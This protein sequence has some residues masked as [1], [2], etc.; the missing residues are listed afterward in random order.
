ARAVDERAAIYRTL[1]TC[2]VGGESVPRRGF[3][4]L[5]EASDYP[6]GVV[7]PH[8]RTHAGPKKDRLDLLEATRADVG[9]LFMLV[10][11]PGGELLRAT[12]PSGEPVAEARDLQ[13]ELHRLW[14]LT[15]EACI[16]RVQQLLEPRQA[17]RAAGPARYETAV[18]YARRH[19]EATEK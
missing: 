5:G 13:G 4:A 6:R 1:T 17:I 19:P 16:A 7:L 8:E 14:R 12:A 11:D 2:G 3:V 15:D 18:A 10:S 9:L